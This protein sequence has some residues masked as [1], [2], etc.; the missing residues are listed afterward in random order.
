VK[1]RES[2]I[3]MIA[4]DNYKTEVLSMKKAST[5]YNLNYLIQ[6]L[7]LEF[8]HLKISSIDKKLIQRYIGKL[9]MTIG[10]AAIRRYISVFRSICMW[11]D[12][13]FVLPRLTLPR[14]RRKQQDFYTTQEMRDLIKAATGE[15]KA[16]IMLFC[17]TGVRI[18]EVLGLQTQDLEGNTLHIRR[19]VSQ[20]FLQDSPKT[21]SS[22]RSI[23]ISDELVRELKHLILGG[24]EEFIFRKPDDRM[25]YPTKLM[26]MIQKVCT[27]A[28]VKYKSPHAFRRGN[29]TSLLLDLKIPERVVGY[30]AGHNSTSSITLGIY[31][32]ATLG[33]DRE[34]V[35]K[36][37]E[38]FY[39]ETK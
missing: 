5:Y 37:V 23:C 17:E 3:F 19:D 35:P 30:R 21:D 15:D 2:S 12:E 6:K 22:V 7:V 32:M 16:L 24:P 11:A 36:I 38:L 28:G 26:K 20:G 29:I 31:C 10:A 4:A 33:C 25:C 8:G 27:K 39:G 1:S 13:E 9:N 18:G 14:K 34:W